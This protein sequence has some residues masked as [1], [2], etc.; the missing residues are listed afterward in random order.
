MTNFSNL[1]HDVNF[2]GQTLEKKKKKKKKDI[3]SKNRLQQIVLQH[4]NK[5]NSRFSSEN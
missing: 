5:F 4:K 1:Y 3:K 2:M